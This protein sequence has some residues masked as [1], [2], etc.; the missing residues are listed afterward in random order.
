MTSLFLLLICAA[1]LIVGVGLGGFLLL[2]KL[3]VIAHEAS[4]PV[5]QDQGVYT[6]EQGRE[7]RAEEQQNDRVRQ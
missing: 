2:V 5:H 6:L 1:I 3:G 7:V 4:R